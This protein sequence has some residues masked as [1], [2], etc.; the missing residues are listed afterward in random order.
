MDGL[1]SAMVNIS[2]IYQT[3]EFYAFYANDRGAYIKQIGNRNKK[4]KLETSSTTGR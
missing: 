3:G 1:F 4:K 2:H